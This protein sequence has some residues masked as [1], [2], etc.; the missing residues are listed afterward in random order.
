[1]NK[2]Q[3]KDYFDEFPL[4]DYEMELEE[5]LE[6]GEFVS[7]KNFEKRKKEL[8]ESAKNFLE[9]QK[10]KRITLR[11]KNEDIIKVK[12]KAKRVNIP[13]QRLLN[14]LIHKYAEGKT[15]ITI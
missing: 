10:T 1:M 5:F 12:A 9:L 15:S 11:V 13:Y 2:K 4:D 3:K 6:K 8:E 7:I 14:V